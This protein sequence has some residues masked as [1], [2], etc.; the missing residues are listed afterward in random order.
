M[1]SPEG[2]E[3]DDIDRFLKPTR[4]WYFKP[5]TYGLGK[6]GVSDIIGCIPV[7]ITEQM[8]GKEIGV[9]FACE[10]KRPMKEPTLL[11]RNR[12][13]DIENAGGK[14]TWGTAEMVI[15]DLKK[16]IAGRLW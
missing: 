16:W 2:R 13:I 14:G 3:K 10:V 12:I 1:R 9:F 8:V 11:Q 6:S 5:A 7:T 15:P 4:V